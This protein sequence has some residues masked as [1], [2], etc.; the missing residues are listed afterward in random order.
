MFT[1]SERGRGLLLQASIQDVLVAVMIA[2]VSLACFVA[3]SCGWIRA[4]ARVAER[5]G[6]FVAGVLLIHGDAASVV[7]AVL[8]VTATLGFHL[9]RT[10]AGDGL[11]A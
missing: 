3:A 8:I 7:V 11:A 9:V 10:R 4:E 1:L 6:A 2:S 5:T